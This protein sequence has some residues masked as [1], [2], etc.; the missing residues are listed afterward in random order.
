MRSPGSGAARVWME[1]ALRLTSVVLAALMLWASLRPVVSTRAWDRAAEPAL[2]AAAER[3]TRDGRL[4]SVHVALDTV[5]S[6]ELRAW[7]RALR[8]AGVRVAWRGDAI[9][10]TA[11]ELQRRNEPEGGVTA[12][13]AAPAGEA[14]VIAD[15]AGMVDSVRAAGGG[16]ALRLA[17]VASPVRAE[18]G[19]Q[20][21]RAPEPP[22]LAPRRVLVLGAAGWEAK[23]TI[24]ALEERGW[25]VDAR[26]RVAPAVEVAQGSVAALDTARHAAVVVLDTTAGAWSAR[27]A[28]FV[29][30]GGGLVLA[31]SAARTSGLAALAPAAPGERVRPASVAFLADAPRRALGFW[32]LVRLAPD[33]VPLETRDGRVSAAARRVG[34]G[35]VVQVGDDESWRWRMEGGD[36]APEA[37]RAWW[38]SVVA[39]AS[40]RAEER[41]RDHS[42]ADGIDSTRRGGPP[43]TAESTAAPT[44][45]SHPSDALATGASLGD[46]APL[47]ALVDALGPPAPPPAGAP[48]APEPPAL[49]GWMLA[50]LLLSLL[51]EWTSRRLRGA[52]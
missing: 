9:P 13:I 10:A 14:V 11:L 51:A 8:R 30:S 16:A 39:S 29:R 25:E 38:S 23:F 7:L 40:Y 37:H 21:A 32:P 34:A 17:A 22:R 49:R 20:A 41:A 12:L 5:P 1:R 26:L 19:R 15:A 35:R 28:R 46:A 43:P 6:A 33:A 2:V 3:W 4:D 27:I 45:R 24:A 18:V 31:G 44:D 42:A 52:P 50:A 47:A 48:A 36:E